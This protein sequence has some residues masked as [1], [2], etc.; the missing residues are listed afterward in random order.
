[1]RK[2]YS[3]PNIVLSQEIAR[4]EEND[5]DIVKIT[6][7]WRICSLKVLDYSTPVLESE[8]QVTLRASSCPAYNLLVMYILSAPLLQI[9]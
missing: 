3:N 9:Q 5:A 4:K 6:F 8:N 1:M 2:Y 7:L